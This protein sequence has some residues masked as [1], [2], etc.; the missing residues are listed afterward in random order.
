MS[1]LEKYQDQIDAYVQ[2][3]MTPR[4]IEDFESLMSSNEVLAE[5]V[6]R[7]SSFF[8]SYES[9]SVLELNEYLSSL[10]GNSNSSKK[11]SSGRIVW[12]SLLAASLIG[13]IFLW[14]RSIQDVPYEQFIISGL[15]DVGIVDP[16]ITDLENATRSSRRSGAE[17]NSVDNLFADLLQS[18]EEMTPKNHNSE[19][20]IEYALELSSR[21]EFALKYSNPTKILISRALL[22]ENRSSDAFG[23]LE[24]VEEESA[25]DCFAIYYSWIASIQDRTLEFE[26]DTLKCPTFQK[27]FEN[28]KN[29]LEDQK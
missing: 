22:L 18:F 25:Y 27:A 15:D 11:K 12:A 4:E 3:R 16:A 9:K 17:L 19:E 13:F 21:Q 14:V 6:N 26:F 29:E 28:L 2:G 24:T 20:F 7:L 23:V 10:R 5:E 1:S 8:K